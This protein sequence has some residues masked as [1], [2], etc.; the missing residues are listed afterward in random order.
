MKQLKSSFYLLLITLITV[1]VSA[2]Q[3][4]VAAA[5]SV[6]PT[7]AAPISL[8]LAQIKIT[9]D[10]FIVLQN[11]APT[12]I[13]DLSQYSLKSFNNVNRVAAGVNSAV[14][15]L[16]ATI[17]GAGQRL[18]LSTNTRNTCGAS[19][20]GKL[21]LSLVDGGGFLEILQTVNGVSTAIDSVSWSSGANGVI[22]TVPTSAKDPQ[23]MY[24]RYASG[25]AFNWQLADQDPTNYCQLSVA[26]VP[27]TSF[28]SAIDSAP[29]SI[30]VTSN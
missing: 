11:N 19:I 14:Q 2:P 24:Y 4:A 20:A 26:T 15:Q 8:S 30:V 21:S 1:G 9:G 10:E 6:A 29:A 27:T 18:I 12:E 23:G 3:L 7:P 13:A 28:I 17:L 5:S 22:P 25:T 16:P